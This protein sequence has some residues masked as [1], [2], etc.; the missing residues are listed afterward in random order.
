MFVLLFYGLLSIGLCN[1]VFFVNNLL[2]PVY[3][4]NKICLLVNI[5]LVLTIIYLEIVV[6]RSFLDNYT[7]ILLNQFTFL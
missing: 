1:S 4:Q 2:L 6:K 7:L 3:N 5:L